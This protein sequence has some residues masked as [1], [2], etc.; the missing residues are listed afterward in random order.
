MNSSFGCFF[1][2]SF[3]SVHFI[4][5]RRGVIY[6]LNL[7]PLPPVRM[8]KCIRNVAESCLPKGGWGAGWR[9]SGFLFFILRIRQGLGAPTG[10]EWQAGGRCLNMETHSLSFVQSTAVLF[11]P[12]A[13]E[14]VGE[15]GGEV[16]GGHKGPSLSPCTVPQ[17][18]SQLCLA[19]NLHHPHSTKQKQTTWFLSGHL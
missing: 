12:T 16:A 4:E 9:G 1:F 6:F 7:T 18:I 19:P 14:V 5:C 10:F 13:A 15:G 11:G 17:Q 3:L 8:K 2:F